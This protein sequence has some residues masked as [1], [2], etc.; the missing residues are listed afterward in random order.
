[1]ANRR[2][3]IKTMLAAS[4]A[5]STPSLLYGNNKLSDKWSELLPLRKLGKTGE[6][7]TMLGVGG[8]HIGLVEETVAQQIIET[9]IA[10]GVRFFD[11]AE[12]YQKG[13]S[14]E[15]YGKFLTPK[16]RDEIFLMT[17]TQ[18][19]T[20]AEAK[21]HLEDSLRRMKTDYIDLWQMHSLFTPAD[22]DDRLGNGV[23]D[24]VLKAKQDGKVKHIGFTGHQNPFAHKRILEL[25]RNN[26][27]FETAQMPVNVLDQS[28]FS[29]QQNVLPEL[30]E[31]NIG[32][33]AMKTLA[34]GRFFAE[35]KIRKWKTDDPVIPNYISIKEA[36][37]FAWSMPVSTIITGADNAEM[38]QEKIDMARNFTSLT[39][40][41]KLSLVE[42]LK[43][44]ALTGK[45]EYYK[46]QT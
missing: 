27:V 23:L 37:Y 43:D 22:V 14:E 2:D 24:V 45:V 15:R 32:V 21:Q 26:D 33:L 30:I 6:N 44:K 7:I 29:F 38:M 10:G 36:M 3:F 34:D 13:L 17:K 46:K 25:T 11:S 41:Q 5:I 39:T 9:A 19:K 31:R 4:A 8:F 35:K 18:A 40:K 1:M 42:K 20:A 12:R 16:Y 28:Y